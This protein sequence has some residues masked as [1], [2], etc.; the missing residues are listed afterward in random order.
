M[1]RFCRE[2]VE[3]HDCPVIGEVST[4]QRKNPEAIM[5]AQL[6]WM[7]DRFTFF[8]KEIS[9]RENESQIEWVK[10]TMEGN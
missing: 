6:K 1:G 8:V 9:W 7:Y 3:G 5:H 10:I 4:I 2:A